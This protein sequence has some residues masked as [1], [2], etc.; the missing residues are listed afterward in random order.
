MPEPLASVTAPAPPATRPPLDR[1]LLRQSAPVRRAVG[2]AVALGGIAACSVVAQAASLAHL[3]AA[4]WASQGRSWP[5]VDLVVLLA[6]GVVRALTVLLGEPA[7]ESAA[8]RAVEGLRA[9]IVDGIVHGES[10]WR[11]STSSGALLSLLTRGLDALGLYLAR[12]LPALVLSVVAPIVVL[13]WIIWVD[14]WSAA[15]IG[16][17]VLVLPVFMVLLGVEASGRMRSTWGATSRLTGHFADVSRGMRTLRSFNRAEAQVEVLDAAGE[18]LRRL[19]MGTLQ[20]ALLSSFTLELLSSLATAIVALTLGL[21]LLGGHISLA[22]ALGVLLVTPEV[23]LPLRR[24]S[25]QFH[26]ATDGVGAAGDLLDLVERRP[27]RRT[28]TSDRGSQVVDDLVDG[29]SPTID[30][31]DVAISHD[32]LPVWDAP[33]SLHVQAGSTLNLI[34]ASG[35]GKS[36]LLGVLL[37]QIVPDSGTVLIDGVPMAELDLLAWR[38]AIGWLPQHPTFPGATLA[39]VVRMRQPDLDDAEVALLL[40]E[41][42]LGHLASGRRDLLGTPGVE[43]VRSLSTGERHRLA[44]LRA[45]LGSPRLLLLDEPGAHL[46]PTSAAAVTS[47]LE[48][49][50]RGTTTIVVSHE[51][52]LIAPGAVQH[53][54]N[55]WGRHRG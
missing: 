22:T 2:I 32:D 36:T 17:T 25:A 29:R 3:L 26:D 43:A 46:D 49:R 41:V 40:G 23:Y 21:R 45:V 7:T 6:A 54:I 37:G 31:V 35:A 53:Q 52:S 38:R 34:G 20:V 9:P 13:A 8:D 4:A 19:T 42:G 24:A 5:V 44:V 33:L 1:R 48:H 50:A 30:L 18:D 11:S 28:A 16:V 27:A 14:P 15:I 12:T 10:W 51:A 39:D 47:L 55:A